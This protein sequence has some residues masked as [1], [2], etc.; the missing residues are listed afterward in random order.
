MIRVA[1]FGYTA[2]ANNGIYAAYLISFSSLGFQHMLVRG[3]LHNQ[4]PVKTLSTES[5]MISPG[6]QHLA[7]VVTFLKELSMSYATPLG[8]NSWKLVSGFLQ[9]LPHVPF[10]FADFALYLFA[11]INLIHEY[12]YMLSPVNPSGEL[13]KLEVVLGIL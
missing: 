3:C 7:R 4:S 13:P 1:L 6:R 9:I 2:C 12:N 11:V 10:P 5:L 8:E